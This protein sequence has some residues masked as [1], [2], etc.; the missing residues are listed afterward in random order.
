MARNMRPIDRKEASHRDR[1]RMAN[2]TCLDA[3]AYMIGPWIRKRLA[4]FREP[5][6]SGELAGH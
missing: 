3:D 2:R 4:Y 1:I 6:W 5:S